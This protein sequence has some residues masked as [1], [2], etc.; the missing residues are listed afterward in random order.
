MRLRERKRTQRKSP[1]LDELSD[2]EESEVFYDSSEE[3]NIDD[4][5]DEDEDDD[6]DDEDDDLY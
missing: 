5:P 6:E 1:K 3:F 4:E 2:D